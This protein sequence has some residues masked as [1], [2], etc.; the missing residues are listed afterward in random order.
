MDNSKQNLWLL[1]KNNDC[2]TGD[3][4]QQLE[5]ESPWYV[6][7]MIGFSAW[8]A[9]IF[10]LG[11]I[12]SV[13]E[14]IFDNKTAAIVFSSFMICIAYFLLRTKSLND[15]FIQFALVLSFAGQILFAFGVFE[16]H[17]ISNPASWL[18]FFILQSI[19]AWFMPSYTHRVTSSFMAAISLS[20]A[21]M[22]LNI[23][24]IQSALLLSIVA[25]LWVNEFKW[26]KKLNPL[27]P[28]AYGVTL[29]LIYQEGTSLFHRSYSTLMIDGYVENDTFIQPW[30]G[31]SLVGIVFLVIVRIILLK[32]KI[33]IPSKT[34]NLIFIGTGILILASI[35][36]IGLTVGV[37]IILL[38]YHNANRILMGLGTVSLLFYISSYYYTLET[39]LLEKSLLLATVGI[40]LLMGS[41]VIHYLLPVE[42]EKKHES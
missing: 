24:F 12:A 34:S 21:M 23:F 10:L 26:G 31:E 40:L 13:F 14:F 17:S 42:G 11:L 2:V 5:I 4:P 25:Y 19:L 7:V 8:L 9:A 3:Y 33:Q 32:Q 37:I 38:G 20:L 16:V 6:R 36:A 27:I 35:K 18:Y 41:A 29:G 1:L 28:I 15:F 39:T 30:M 22:H